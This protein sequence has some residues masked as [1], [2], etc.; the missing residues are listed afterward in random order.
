MLQNVQPPVT[1]A[2]W[3][4]PM[5]TFAS[6]PLIHMI[7]VFIALVS[8]SILP[9][10]SGTD[11]AQ[12][13]G[14]PGGPDGPPEMGGGPGRREGSQGSCMD[15]ECRG[16]VSLAS[17]YRQAHWSSNVSINFPDNC[18]MTVTSDGLPSHALPAK[19]LMPGRSAVVAS[20]PAAHL[21]LGLYDTPK[22]PHYT[23]M[24]YN[25]CPKKSEPTSTSMGTIGMMIS[26]GALFNALEGT[27]VPALTDN[28]TFDYKDAAGK[29]QTAAFLDECNGHFTP[30][31]PPGVVYHYH[32]VPTCITSKVDTKDGPSHLIGI[33]LDGFPVYGGRDMQG[34][35][36]GLEQL[37]ACN[38]I[39]S[40][41]PEFPG[42]VYHYVLPEGVTSKRSSLTCYSGTVSRRLFGQAMDAGVCTTVTMAPLTGAARA[43]PVPL[44]ASRNTS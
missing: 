22:T 15:A 17:G 11:M 39:N 14:W 2:A 36:I 23:T 35:V 13:F 1:N 12:G 34:K 6:N 43:N 7:P 31:G 10:C 41:T 26:G 16:T 8:V 9:G 30:G 24:S 38:G 3:T 28:V 20:T 33:A 21:Q 25:I 5:R 19:Y 37:D 18:T 40:P 32:G 29:P 44:N 4:P 27:D 42:G